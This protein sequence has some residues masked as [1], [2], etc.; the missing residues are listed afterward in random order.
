MINAAR[1][2]GLCDEISNDENECTTPEYDAAHSGQMPAGR[3]LLTPR[4]LNR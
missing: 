4:F 1:I 3:E 2:G